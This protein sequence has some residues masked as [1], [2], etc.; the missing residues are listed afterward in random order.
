MNSL[1]QRPKA[2]D[3]RCFLTYIRAEL[4]P[5]IQQAAQETGFKV[6]AEV[7]V[8][9]YKKS[10]PAWATVWSDELRKI[11]HG[12]FWQAFDRLKKAKDRANRA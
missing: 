2:S 1:S 9:K 7:G 8:D 4:A 3:N 5:L 6:C 10:K 12:P 11:D